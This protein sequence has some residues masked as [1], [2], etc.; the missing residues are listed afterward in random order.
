MPEDVNDENYEVREIGE[1]EPDMK[2]PQNRESVGRQAGHIDRDSGS[3][4]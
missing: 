4:F 2:K 1:D 3:L